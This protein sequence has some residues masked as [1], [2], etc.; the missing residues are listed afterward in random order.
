MAVDRGDVKFVLSA[1]DSAVAAA[2]NGVKAKADAATSGIST[3]FAGLKAPIGAVGAIF[4][5]LSA[6]LST[7]FVKTITDTVEMTEKAMDMG[8]ALGITTN[9]ARGIQVAL[10]DIGAETGEYQAAAKGMVRQLAE[11]EDKMNA[12]GLPSSA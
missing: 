1:D 11:N 9:E 7:V 3:A 4:A 5:T 6:V 8:R 10:K 12:M 2:F